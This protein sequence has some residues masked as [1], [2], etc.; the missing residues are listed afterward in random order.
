MATK[1]KGQVSPKSAAVAAAAPA[2]SPVAA[3]VASVTA[4]PVAPAPAT[5]QIPKA[6]VLRGGATFSAVKLGAHKYAVSAPHNVAA[7]AAVTA[8]LQANDGTAPVQAVCKAIAAEPLAAKCGSAA[9]MVAY[10]VR[11]GALASV[12]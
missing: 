11:R 4:A 5:A 1:N 3:M 6:V 2:P 10:L 7:W 12:A 9:G 8:C